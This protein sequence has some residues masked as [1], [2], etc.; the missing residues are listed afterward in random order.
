MFN[1]HA[2][3]VVQ[4]SDKTFV[5]LCPAQA[6]HGAPIGVGPAI[7]VR[8]NAEGLARLHRQIHGAD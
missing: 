3:E 7:R 8:E 2:A 4:R 1:A 5:V 6:C